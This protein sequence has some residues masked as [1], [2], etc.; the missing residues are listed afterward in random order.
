MDSKSN[1]IHKN[2]M[3]DAKIQSIKS[4]Y[5]QQLLDSNNNQIN[6]NEMLDAKI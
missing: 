6:K 5:E 3:V 4:L 1:Q 2:E